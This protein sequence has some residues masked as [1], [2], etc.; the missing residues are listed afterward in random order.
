MEAIV[1]QEAELGSSLELLDYT[2]QKCNQQHD[3]IVRRLE[4]CEEMLRNLERGVSAESDT[5]VESLLSEGER[6]KW[7]R[8]KE[9]VITIL[10]EVLARLEDN[11]ELNNA[12]IRDVRDKMD[13]LRAKRL[14]L[15]EEIAI[16]EEDIALTLADKEL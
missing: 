3:E 1:L 6:V 9:M 8:T 2:R 5:A 16:K 12:K 14:A 15:R 4:D 7:L 13:E 10:P 11:I